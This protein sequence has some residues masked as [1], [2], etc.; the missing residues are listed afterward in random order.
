MKGNN[1]KNINCSKCDEK[2][3]VE[4][5]VAKV[6]CSSCCARIGTSEDNV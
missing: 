4:K 3:R 6:T 2:V 1:M 5:D